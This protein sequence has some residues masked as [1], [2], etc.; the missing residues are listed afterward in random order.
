MPFLL[1]DTAQTYYLS[2]L[3]VPT[4][5]IEYLGD[6]HDAEDDLSSYKTT[7]WYW[8]RQCKWTDLG[9]SVNGGILIVVGGQ[10]YKAQLFIGAYSYN[11]VTQAALGVRITGAWNNIY[12][13]WRSFQ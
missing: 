1:Y 6:I 13:S 3:G 11:N 9:N 7:G 2:L 5:A 10:G 12:S 8:V 4:S